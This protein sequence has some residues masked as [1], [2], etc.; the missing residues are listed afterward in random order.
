MHHGR[1]LGKEWKK[2][3]LSADE[4]AAKVDAVGADCKTADLLP[5]EMAILDYA[6]KLT[7]RPAEMVAN[8][9]EQLRNHGLDDRAIHDLCSCVA[10]FAFVNRIADGLGVELESD[11]ST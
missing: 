6:I 3:G 1:G 7:Q 2:A 4:A 10:Y 5:R 9:V 11:R 8:D